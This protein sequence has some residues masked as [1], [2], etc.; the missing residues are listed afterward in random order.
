VASLA[1]RMITT[2]TITITTT[3]IDALTTR[4]TKEA[5]RA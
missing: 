2:T 5:L 3:T 1:A 4:K